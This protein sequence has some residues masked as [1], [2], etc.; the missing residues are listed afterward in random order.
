MRAVLLAF[1]LGASLLLAQEAPPPAASPETPPTFPGRVEQVTVDVVVA[2]K[3]GVPVRGLTREDLEVFEDGVRQTLVSFEAV[4]V[5][6]AAS[7]VSRPRPRIST[8]Q[9]A[10]DAGGR[11]FVVLFDDAHLTPATA[12]R[13]K[14]AVADFLTHGVREGDRVTL[15]ASLAGAW[16]ST[17]MEAGRDELIVLVKRLDGRHVPEADRDR[18]TDQEA[19]RVYTRRDAEVAA[20]VQ[21]R[22]QQLGVIAQMTPEP[23]QARYAATSIDPYVES[24]AR[25]VYFQATTRNRATLRALE[26][27]LE[28]LNATR[29]RKSLI[30]VSEGFIYDPNLGEF[31]SVAQAA[32]RANTAVYFVNARGLEGMPISMTAQFGPPVPEVDLGFALDD[33]EAAEGA[34]RIASES[35][36]FIV[37]DTNDLSG[38]FRRIADENSSYYLLGYNPTNTARDGA[39]RKISVR[40]P[41]RKGL[42]V[43]AR[44]GYYA[45]G[46]GEDAGRKRGLDAVFQEAL[47]SPFELVGIPLR[48]THFVGDETLLGK[49]RVELATELDVRAL[50]LEERDGR[51]LGGVDF[52]LVAAHGETGEHSRYDQKL[53]LQ[54]L[55]ASR[56]RMEKTWFSVVREFDLRPGAYQAKVVARDM[57]SG[58]VGT[59]VHEFEVPD[60]AAFRVSTPVLT[61]RRRPGGEGPLGQLVPVARR[62]FEQGTVLYCGFEVYG[63]RKDDA[64]MPRV[65]M[66]YMVKR[67]DGTVFRWVDPTEI[68]PTS[69]GKLSR[70]FLL[71]LQSTEPG[72]YELVM[73]F[74]DELSGKSLEIT[75]PFTVLAAGERAGS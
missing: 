57:R 6:P 24:R 34:E 20:R 23:S 64:G 49:A 71:G 63:A 68:R 16:W 59:A 60:P 22:F 39:F 40:V 30:L 33:Y 72:A 26:R 69:L 55:P 13:A 67:A 5:P 7:A 14:G 70:S 41:G 47:D 27:S 42:E 45:P 36:G 48:M 50:D 11:T 65:A 51:H 53:E 10:D 61:D 1:P 31:K 52:L 28:A 3:K 66:G 74:R 25:D 54:L 62:E 4:E 35:G 56:K 8:N 44:K 38:G 12:H 15:V 75:E 46:D 9:E 73:T 2:D 18:M 29:G 17:R 19:M 58:R 32:R 43:R 21:R 37:R